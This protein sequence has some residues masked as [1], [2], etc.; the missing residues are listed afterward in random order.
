MLTN[1]RNMNKQISFLPVLSGRKGIVEVVLS[2]SCQVLRVVAACHELRLA[3]LLA[4]RAAANVCDVF[5][6]KRNRSHRCARRG[7]EASGSR[8][9]PPLSSSPIRID[10]DRLLCFT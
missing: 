4:V 7:R 1:L 8:V 10:Q 3:L 5:S 2:L 9:T 6:S